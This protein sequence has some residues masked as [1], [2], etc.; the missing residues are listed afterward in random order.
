M[1]GF[2]SCDGAPVDK[3][4]LD[5]AYEGAKDVSGPDDFW[6]FP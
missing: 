3:N 6:Q 1:T 5:L 4:H 2:S